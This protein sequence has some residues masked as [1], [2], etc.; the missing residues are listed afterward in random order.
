MPKYIPK[1]ISCYATKDL[2]LLNCPFFPMQSQPES[3]QTSHHK[4]WYTDSKNNYWNKKKRSRIAK[5]VLQ[6][7]EKF[8]QLII[9]DFKI[10]SKATVIKK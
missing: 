7:G 8:G 5:I 4:I 6:K 1:D 2:R 3:Q 9:S 10:Y